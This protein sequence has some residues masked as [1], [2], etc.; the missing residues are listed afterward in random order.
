MKKVVEREK[1][2]SYYRVSHLPIWLWVFFILP[3][4]LTYSLYLHGPDRR[5]AIWLAV[6]IAVCAWR[7]SLGRL[8]GVEPKPYVTHF[9]VHQPNLPYRVVCYTAAWIGILVPFSLN[10]IG[11]AVAAISGRWLMADLYS[12][13]YYPMALLVVLATWMDW[14]PRARRST[15]NEG[16]EK[17][18]FYV[19]IWMVVPSQVA[20]WAAWRLG[21]GLG[22]DPIALARFRFLVFMLVA[23]I[24]FFL[25]FKER[26]P[27][28]ARYHL[29][30]ADNP[31]GSG[32]PELSL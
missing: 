29:S 9:G 14:T 31:A 3:G 24:F 28:T 21:G 4:H 7:G 2:K 22:L 32:A 10:L 25:A 12:Y 30:Q 18:W 5:H 1:N 19:G 6:V 27:R 26:L 16:A 17:A 15:L 13:V 8:P 23:A 11:L 20:V